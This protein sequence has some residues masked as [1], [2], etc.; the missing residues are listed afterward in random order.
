[1][2]RCVRTSEDLCFIPH[3]FIEHLLNVRLSF[4]AL[5][6]ACS[7]ICQKDLSTARDGLYPRG[8][9]G[10]A[11]GVLRSEGETAPRVGGDW[12]LFLR[13]GK[14]LTV[15][16][17]EPVMGPWQN[18]AGRFS[19]G[20]RHHRVSPWLSTQLVSLHLSQGIN[21]FSVSVPHQP[22]RKRE[23]DRYKS[24]LVHLSDWPGLPLGTPSF[25]LRSWIPSPQTCSAQA[26]GVHGAPA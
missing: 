16:S 26:K 22:C 19:C 6:S 9:N 8:R 4:S 14:E 3:T 10:A 24:V 18:M 13:G 21:L 5:Q 17:P 1:M 2:W 11:F 12:G 23:V 25:T 7:C 15:F 20:A